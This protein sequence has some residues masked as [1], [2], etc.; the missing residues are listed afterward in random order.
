MHPSISRISTMTWLLTLASTLLIAGCGG[1]KDPILG[2]S[3]G[4]T[5]APSVSATAPLASNPVVSGVAINTQVT[6]TFNKA[7]NP[8]TLT[9]STFTLACP[10][11]TA[12]PGTV[13]YDI[14]S[15][16]ATFSPTN[17]LPLSTRCVATIT[18][19]AQDTNG[20]PLSSAFAW[21]F[22]TGSSTDGLAPTVI[23]QTPAQDA[24]AAVNTLMTATFSEDMAPATINATSFT[25]K[26]T[27]GD[28]PVVGSVSYAVG[29]RTATFTPTAPAPLPSNTAFTAT[30]ST[31]A[32]DLAGN[33]LTVDKVWTFT[34]ADVIDTTA[35]TVTL[36]NPV[37]AGIAVCLN[38]TVNT[39]FS[40]PMDPLTLTTTTLTLAPSASLNLP[41]VAVITYDA[42]TQVASINPSANLSPSTAYTATVLSGSG[43]VKDLA[44]NALVAN[45]VWQFTTGT[46]ECQ[47]PVVLASSSN[48][49][50]LGSA[51]INN[52]PTSLIT[53]DVGLTPDTGASITG[54]ST[55][56]T[57]PEVVGHVYAVDGTGPA[58][59]L[60]NPTLLSNAKT[61]V[62]SAYTN[63]IGAGRGTPTPITTN[64]AGLTFYPGLYESLTSIDLS[65]GSHLTLDAQGDT[66]AVF[67]IRSATSITTL[68][69][70][71]I[72]L[73]GGAKASNVFWT[74]GS[75][76]TLGTSSVMKGTMLAGTAITLQTGANLEGRALNQG[77]AAEA[78]SCDACTITVPSP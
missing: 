14:N 43:G 52:I 72:V 45:K 30:I 26:T 55:P 56:A 49:A 58:C 13:A 28:T 6:A 9:T 2:S 59:A 66:N 75:A 32:T 48:F 29:A 67:V 70:S 71:Q 74:A 17:N 78:I 40:E 3:N 53:G 4:S 16:V 23:S 60:I 8:V 27:V 57:C 36:T 68:S 25:L 21:S 54:F 41:V 51:A 34:T 37:D 10:L 7:M 33:P 76:I 15:R 24:V 44:S 62:L 46:S 5:L 38:K 31:V 12:V 47:T 61:D 73:S 39:T 19:D 22:D 65:A 11:G 35:P 64:L 77:A 69:T 1:G 20:T 50:I 63:A 18:T 42:G